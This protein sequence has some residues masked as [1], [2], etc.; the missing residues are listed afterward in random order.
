MDHAPSVSG[1]ASANEAGKTGQGKAGV[2]DEL[3]G[4]TVRG[5]RQDCRDHRGRHRHRPDDGRGAGAGG[6]A[7][8]DRLA[9]GRRLR[10]GGGGTDG[11]RAGQ[12]RGLR[13]R[14]GHRGRRRGA[15]SG[16]P[17]A[18]RQAAHPDQQRRQ[19]L[20]GALRGISLPRLEHGDVGQLRRA[21]HPDPRHDPLAG[22]RRDRRRPGA[23]GQ[24][25]LGC[26]GRAGGGPGVFLCRLQGRRA[27]PDPYPG[28]GAGR[29][30]DH[31]QRAG[32]G[33]VPEPDDQT[34]HRGR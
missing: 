3:S 7:G 14:R 30:P 31:R 25:R 10:A 12:R 32:A 27:P 13:G 17:Q 4:A 29:A 22:G 11:H 24:Y 16:N 5:V 6:G 20:G 9:Q 2:R 1:F 18:H 21:V 28:Q 34:L 23:G 15:D 8:A 33:A 26:R 19:E